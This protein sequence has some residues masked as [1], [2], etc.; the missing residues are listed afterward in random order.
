M[1][2]ELSEFLDLSHT[3]YFD[4]GLVRKSNSSQIDLTNVTPETQE[5]D[6]GH[7]S[8]KDN[9]NKIGTHFACYPDPFHSRQLT[10]I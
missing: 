6:S 8:V 10:N 5:F 2:T 1:E 7:L 4:L 3:H 9:K